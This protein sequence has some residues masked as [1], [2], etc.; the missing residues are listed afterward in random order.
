MSAPALVER[1]DPAAHSV[2]LAFRF[3]PWHAFAISVALTAAVFLPAV[4]NDFVNWDDPIYV[5]ENPPIHQL[6]GQFL[7]WAFTT[8]HTGNWIPLTWLSHAL[9]WWISGPDPRGHHLSSV[10]LHSLNAGLVAWL[11]WRML[12]A[13]G[14][15]RRPRDGDRTGT[16]VAAALSGV[17]FGI[18]PLRVESVAW[19]AER[20]D[21]LSGTFFLGSLI[22]Y[23]HYGSS[24]RRPRRWLFAAWL[25][26]VLGYLS[27][28]MVM[29]LPV[30]LLVL[31]EWP[32]ER[33]A[34]ERWKLVVEKL[35][36]FGT[37]L[38][39]ALVAMHSQSASG[40]VSSF[41]ARPPGFRVLHAFESVLFYAGK[42]LLPVGLSPFYA[43]SS[44]AG[45]ERDP[46]HWLPL[47]IVVVVTAAL[48]VIALR[49][50]RAALAAWV[51]YGVTLGPV[52]GLVQIGSQAY[53]DRY[54]YI[55]TLSVGLV[56]A[57]AATALVRRLCKTSRAAATAAA[58]GVVLAISAF[59]W[60]SVRQIHV[61]RDSVHLW[62]RV[63]TLHP[64]ASPLPLAN[65]A[66]AYLEE[67][68]FD[69]ALHAASRALALDP[70]LAVAHDVIGRARLATGDAAQARAAFEQA[71]RFDPTNAR[72]WM[73]LAVAQHADGLTDEETVSLRRAT[74]EARGDPVPWLRLAIAL[75]A[76]GDRDGAIAAFRR[77]A[78]LDPRV[79]DQMRE[80][81]THLESVPVP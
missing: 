57:S 64:N 10:L 60:L 38:P 13:A 30:V 22:A 4:S 18:H 34:R 79:A 3:R 40:A 50:R 74:A 39:L 31:D 58:A 51:Y 46:L 28:A 41:N 59:A 25:L 45:Y 80:Q 81:I 73:N 15:G 7:R 33:W 68:R 16:L 61:W 67:S 42:W 24:D 14:R 75:E 2:D 69:D 54:T 48:A 49:G 55:P 66:N 56:A 6:D 62:E 52:I 76:S 70:G 43:P 78:E 17:L 12:D 5:T 9:D 47:V 65:L 27:K 29:T 32:L 44:P 37:T 8:H 77:V 21:V 26:F 23:V 19:I 35:P 53:A 72:I 63:V 71:G 36:F 11:S 1:S 20:K